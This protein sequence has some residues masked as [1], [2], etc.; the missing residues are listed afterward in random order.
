MTTM[1]RVTIFVDWD[2]ARRVGT[3]RAPSVRN[4]EE[5]FDRLQKAIALHLW[6]KNKK[7][8]FRVYW[9][10]YHGWHQGKTKTP[11][12]LLFEEYTLRASARTIGNVSF[13][14][15]YELSGSLSCGSSRAPIY[16]TCRSDRETG[17]TKQKMVDTMLVCDLLHLVRTKD[18]ALCILIAD[19][20]DFVPAMFTAEA[21][22]GNVVMLHGREH[23]NSLLK[24]DGLTARMQLQ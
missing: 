20:D 22:K 23:M 15:D 6:G 5:V 16:D 1:H 13:S 14:T 2:T 17:Q 8:R 12:R 10:I 3:R 21:W 11:D 4:L 7:D 9:R 19:D 18:S 24:L